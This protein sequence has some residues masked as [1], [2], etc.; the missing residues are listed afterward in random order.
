MGVTTIVCS[1][2]E[3]KGVWQE[4]KC[5]KSRESGLIKACTGRVGCK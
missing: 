2:I 3:C 5:C 1:T 4:V